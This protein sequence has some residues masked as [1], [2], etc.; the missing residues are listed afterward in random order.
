MPENIIPGILYSTRV[1]CIYTLVTWFKLYVHNRSGTNNTRC[2][3][4]RIRELESDMSIIAPWISKQCKGKSQV[5]AIIFVAQPHLHLVAF[6]TMAFPIQ[7]LLYLCNAALLFMLIVFEIYRAVAYPGNLGSSKLSI[8]DER[9]EKAPAVK[10]I[11]YDCIC[12][13]VQRTLPLL[14]YHIVQSNIKPNFQVWWHHAITSTKEIPIL[15]TNFNQQRTEW[16]ATN[17]RSNRLGHRAALRLLKDRQHRKRMNRSFQRTA[18]TMQVG[19]R[20]R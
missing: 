19:P 1:S 20:I 17:R 3:A 4:R 18:H 16:I 11:P 10:H 7:Y 12:R 2:I 8:Q 6:I 9:S 13:N 5:F 14:A 15:V